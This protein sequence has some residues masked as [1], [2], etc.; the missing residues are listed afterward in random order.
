MENKS[1]RLAAIVVEFNISTFMYV[2]NHLSNY[3]KTII[4]FRLV[5]IGIYSPLLKTGLLDTA[6]REFSLA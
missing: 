4:P 2:Y 3:T 5:N 1:N 6:I